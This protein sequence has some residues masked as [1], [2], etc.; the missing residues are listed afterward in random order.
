M[1]YAII[2]KGAPYGE[3]E[4][5]H[6]VSKHKTMENAQKRFDKEYRGTTGIYSHKIVNLSCGLAPA[7]DETA[8][9]IKGD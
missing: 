8:E 7:T 6:I 4:S 5:G 3:N 9:I 1:K 2:Y